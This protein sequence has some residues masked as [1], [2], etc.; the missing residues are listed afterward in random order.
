MLHNQNVVL[1]LQYVGIDLSGE[2]EEENTNV[3]VIESDEEEEDEEEPA[4]KVNLC[5]CK[6]KGGV[7]IQRKVWLEKNIRNSWLVK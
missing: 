7:R 1:F 6:S 4:A 5:T 2:E 3:E